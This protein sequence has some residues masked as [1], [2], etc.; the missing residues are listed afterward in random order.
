MSARIIQEVKQATPALSRL[1][2]SEIQGGEAVAS[3]DDGGR[4]CKVFW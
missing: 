1:H 2:L 3:G 4:G